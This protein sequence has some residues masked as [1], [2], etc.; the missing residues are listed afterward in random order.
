MT[1]F[2]INHTYEHWNELSSTIGVSKCSEV[3]K[4]YIGDRKDEHSVIPQIRQNENNGTDRQPPAVPKRTESCDT[5]LETG[6]DKE[7]AALRRPSLIADG[8]EEPDIEG[9]PDDDEDQKPL[10]LPKASATRTTKKINA[11]VD[12]TGLQMSPE[13]NGVAKKPPPDKK[14]DASSMRLEKRREKRLQRLSG[15]PTSQNV[16]SSPISWEMHNHQ[17]TKM[18]ETTGSFQYPE[19]NSS[20]DRA[21]E[22]CRPSFEYRQP[23]AYAAPPVPRSSDP[24]DLTTRMGEQ[25]IGEGNFLSTLNLEALPVDEEDN[26]RVRDLERDNQKLRRQVQT[27]TV[28]PDIAHAEEV[29]GESEDTKVCRLSKR[30]FWMLM[31]FGFL[32]VAAIGSAAT[33]LP[34]DEKSPL[35][36]AVESANPTTA[37]IAL[38][39]VPTISPSASNAPAT[40]PVPTTSPSISRTTLQLGILAEIVIPGTDLSSLDLESDQ[41][42]A[43]EWIGYDDPRTEPISKS[44]EL[45]E[46]FSLVVLFH[47]TI[48]SSWTNNA[49]WLSG[50]HHCDWEM[51]RCD[52][53]DRIVEVDLSENGLNGTLATE[54]GNLSRLQSGMFTANANLRGTIPSELG[55]TALT[56]LRLSA[57][58]LGGNL[59]SELGDLENL[60]ILD[61]SNNY[62]IEG[63]PSE[64]GRIMGLRALRLSDNILKFTIPS[65]IGKLMQLETIRMHNNFLE[66]QIP[67]EIGDM[68]SLTDL[69]LQDNLLTGSVPTTIGSLSRL[70]FMN[71]GANDLSGPIAS[72]IGRLTQLTMLSLHRNRLTGPIPSEVG[73]VVS[74]KAMVVYDNRLFGEIPS[75]LGE[76]VALTHLSLWSNR[77][78]GSVPEEIEQLSLLQEVYFDDNDLKAGLES[79][80]CNSS[81]IDSPDFAFHSDCGGS[82]PD[83]VCDCCSK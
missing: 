54:L 49:R 46:R 34:T 76:L 78:T 29:T 40:M 71:I 17:S 6:G 48:G 18:N 12:M 79:L 60:Q 7:P 82:S 64:I 42:L 75:E 23:G 15:Q 58:D 39:H 72:E 45:Q 73:L 28:D 81:Q 11:K 77:L 14:M 5:D 74:L 57:N 32:V 24:W 56:S 83:L 44:Q 38:T 50:E 53:E 1:E 8:P 67:S 26:E 62:L 68:T 80:L 47:S 41:Y 69:Q 3:K 9:L 52:Q 30:V 25:T 55:R 37:S 36:P 59:P 10:A 31:L 33:L 65:E 27:I 63:I 4:E 35:I 70:E 20:S 43:L 22:N 66:G 2:S 13:L 51:I 21:G 19:P 16:S 61:V